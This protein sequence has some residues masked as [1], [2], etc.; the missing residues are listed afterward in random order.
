MSVEHIEIEPDRE[1]KDSLRRSISDS[2]RA[3]REEAAASY[4]A[5]ISQASTH[6]EHSHL[7]RGYE[8]LCIH[9]TGMACDTFA[10]ELARERNR[11]RWI[12][13][14]P[15][16]DGWDKIIQTEQENILNAIKQT[17]QQIST[18]NSPTGSVT[19]QILPTDIT[20][21]TEEDTSWANKIDATSHI[22]PPVACDTIVPNDANEPDEEWKESLRRR[23]L[24]QVSLQFIQLNALESEAL[25]AN[26][27]ASG[28][29]SGSENQ[30]RLDY[31]LKQARS[32]ISRW[33]QEEFRNALAREY[34]QRRERIGVEV[35]MCLR[36]NSDY[37]NFINGFRAALPPRPRRLST[38]PL[39]I[40]H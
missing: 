10:A 33:A 26:T 1:W 2:L 36:P 7:T 25:R 23:I 28:P 40:R 13:G 14:L 32:G 16:L 15:M 5:K 27:S 21:L 22:T 19:T 38:P 17:R 6:S 29:S 35:N 20:T 34:K 30:M 37:T 11:H 24:E 12:A 3:M 9:Y 31:E 39:H 8:Q 4:Y 18:V